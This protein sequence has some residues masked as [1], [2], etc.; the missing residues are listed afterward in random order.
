MERWPRSYR[1]DL[2]PPGKE[3]KESVNTQIA[4]TLCA[5]AVGTHPQLVI[6]SDQSTLARLSWIQGDEHKAALYMTGPV[7]LMEAAY[8]MHCFLRNS[9]PSPTH[10]LTDHVGDLAAPLSEGLRYVHMKAGLI[11]EEFMNAMDLVDFY[12]DTPMQAAV[13]RLFVAHE[14]GVL[15]YPAWQ[16]M[17]A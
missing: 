3:F 2:K 16:G 7:T 1:Y 11:S 9:D 13:G 6:F 17:F 10:G 4:H 14:H 12:C 5:S 15:N 8:H